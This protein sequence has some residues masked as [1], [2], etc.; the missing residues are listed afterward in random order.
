M[1][2][3]ELKSAISTVQCRD[4]PSGLAMK[5]LHFHMPCSAAKDKEAEVNK[6]PIERRIARGMH[7]LSAGQRMMK[8]MKGE[9][10][11]LA[12]CLAHGSSVIIIIVTL[13]LKQP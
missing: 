10:E 5:T 2:I 4:P 11:C 8:V 13:L 3:E 7:L 12:L 6:N 9:E 1:R